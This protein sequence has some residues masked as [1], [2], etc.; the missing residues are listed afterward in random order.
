MNDGLF[1]LNVVIDGSN[2]FLRFAGIVYFKWISEANVT[3]S[4]GYLVLQ[5]VSKTIAM[6]YIIFF[7]FLNYS[8]LII[9]LF[10]YH[11][12]QLLFLTSTNRFVY[13]KRMQNIYRWLLCLYIFHLSWFKIPLLWPW[14]INGNFRKVKSFADEKLIDHSNS[15][16]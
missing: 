16:I 2:K 14:R 1:H 5:N 11:L 8:I 13:W 10:F 4:E 7:P 6:F 9:V 15:A 12:A 3:I